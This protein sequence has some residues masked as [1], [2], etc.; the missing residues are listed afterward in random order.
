METSKM[1][2]STLLLSLILLLGL[3]A[4][5][6]GTDDETTET[7]SANASDTDTSTQPDEDAVPPSDDDGADQVL[8][9]G[10]Y[11]VADLTFTVDLGNGSS[12]EY[13]LACLG[14]TATFT[15]DA[16]GLDAIDACLALNEE[17]VGTRLTTD[18]HLEQMCTEIFGGPE[19]A[20]ITGTIDDRTVDT[21][22]DRANGC[23]IDDWDRLLASLLPPAVS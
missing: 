17:T 20:Q 9:A 3:V 4:A 8:G 15:G 11:P 18:D 2:R 16:P 19:V 14:D 23:G 7:T 6:C 13:Q 12:T 21:T 22:V 10:P 5:A 1:R